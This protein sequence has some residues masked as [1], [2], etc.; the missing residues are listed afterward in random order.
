[1][2][3]EVNAAVATCHGSA[4]TV[5]LCL[6]NRERAAHGLRPLRPC[7]SLRRVATRY[8][9]AMVARHF[10]D[11]VSPSGVTLT[12]RVRRSAYLRG[13]RTWTLGENIAYDSDGSP[14][15]IVAEW[16]ASSGHRANILDP[17]YRD[18]GVGIASGLPVGG[19]GATYVTDFGARR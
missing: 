3:A 18:I 17:S 5:V 12:G 13:T 2:T 19:A 10:F 16:M 4:P 14:A 6:L 11:H 1:M 7:G 15:A 9:R 8:A